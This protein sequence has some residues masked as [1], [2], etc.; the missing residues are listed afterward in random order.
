MDDC[1][2]PLPNFNL[3]DDLKPFSTAPGNRPDMEIQYNDTFVVLGGLRT[4]GAG[5]YDTEGEP[6]TRHIGKYQK[7]GINKGLGVRYMACL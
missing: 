5:Q 2:K 1:E 7:K 6:V 4:T 3:D